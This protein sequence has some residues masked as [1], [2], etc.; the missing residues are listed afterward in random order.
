MLVALGLIAVAAW[1]MLRLEP[2]EAKPR[3]IWGDDPLLVAA[4]ARAQDTLPR[5]RQLIDAPGGEALIKL[6][7][8]RG[9]QPYQGQWADIVAHDGTSVQIRIRGSVGVDTLSWDRVEDWQVTLPDGTIHGGHTV[10]AAWRIRHRQ[11]VALPLGARHQLSRFV[12]DTG[13]GPAGAG[14]PK[15]R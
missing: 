8:D 13:E 2:A 9:D 14:G 6:R 4:R 10:V 3:I 11:G 1:R 5:L 15:L 12:D 7:I